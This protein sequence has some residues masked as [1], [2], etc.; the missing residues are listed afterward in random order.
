MLVIITIFISIKWPL[1][2]VR[3]PR[4]FD[5]W[6]LDYGNLLSSRSKCVS[7][8][9]NIVLHNKLDALSALVLLKSKF[10]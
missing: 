9:I 8:V 7:E 2:Y 4:W 3:F 5:S 6:I 1:I 10:R